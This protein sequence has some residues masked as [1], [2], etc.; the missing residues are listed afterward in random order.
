MLQVDIVPESLA[1]SMGPA[2]GHNHIIF[3]SVWI[4]P[5]QAALKREPLG[6]MG[7]SRPQ[8]P[9]VFGAPGKGLWV[10]LARSDEFFVPKYTLKLY[11]H[12]D[13]TAVNL[14]RKL[15]ESLYR[16]LLLN[17]VLVSRFTSSCTQITDQI[18][19]MVTID[20]V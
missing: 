15:Y 16:K 7:R 3:I 8:D 19:Q 18:A 2:Q 4:E 1:D 14:L 9:G 11:A 6:G 20:T 13:F 10:K 17:T 5:W 12:A